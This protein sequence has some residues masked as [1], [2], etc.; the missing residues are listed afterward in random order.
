MG[1]I[2]KRTAFGMN[3]EP[4]EMDGAMRSSEF[5]MPLKILGDS[6]HGILKQWSRSTSCS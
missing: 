3:R 2:Q 5:V 1:G 4:V 6:E